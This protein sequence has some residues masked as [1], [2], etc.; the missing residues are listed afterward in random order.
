MTDAAETMKHWTGKR[1]TGQAALLTVAGL[2]LAACASGPASVGSVAGTEGQPSP[3]YSGHKVGQPYQVHGV[4]YYPKEQPNYDE[5]GIASWYG[6]QFHNQATADGEVFDMHIASAAHKTLPLPS[7]VEVTNL[8]N[9]KKLIV[10]VNDRGP[11]VDGRIID[12]SK[13]AAAELGFVAAGVTK[14]RV[15][16]VGQAADPPGYNPRQELA[17]A[18]KAPPRTAASPDSH[19]LALASNGQPQKPVP[20]SQLKR[21][22]PDEAPQEPADQAPVQQ[23]STQAAPV[24]PPPPAQT[25]ARASAPAKPAPSLPDV[26]ALLSSKPSAA[27]VAR[28]TYDLQA[29]SFATEDAARHFA[30]GLTGGGLPEVQTVND[31]VQLSYRVVV[32]GLAGPAEAAAAR[33]EAMALGAPNIAIVGGS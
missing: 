14:V 7:L 20:Y 24:Q 13:E 17:S 2:T 9:G 10:R 6:Y 12:M 4:W 23:A 28:A 21:V 19:P 5:I 26:D 22:N 11:F 30:S 8:A 29:G 32:H 15:R 18:R 31:G 3:R 16:Y 33:S 25:Y 1:W 27:A